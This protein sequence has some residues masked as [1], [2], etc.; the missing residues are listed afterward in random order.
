L[1]RWIKRSFPPRH[2][3]EKRG[4]T[5]KIPYER[6]RVTIADERGTYA[7][8]LLGDCWF[9]AENLDRTIIGNLEPRLSRI[10]NPLEPRT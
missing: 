4:T 3:D 9:T 6:S 7:I 5:I 1:R 2:N 8:R 10:P